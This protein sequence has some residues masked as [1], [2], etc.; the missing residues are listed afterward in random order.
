MI[1]E[2]WVFKVRVEKNYRS[3]QCRHVARIR[4]KAHAKGDGRFNIE[5]LCHQVLELVMYSLRA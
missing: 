1:S 2:G 4:A 5:K 3:K